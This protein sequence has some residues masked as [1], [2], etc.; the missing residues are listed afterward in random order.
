[1]GV[2]TDHKHDGARGSG[3]EVS[4]EDDMLLDVQEVAEILKVPVS[5]VYERTRRRGIER[6][7]HLKVGK[8]V[9]FRRSEI[10]GYLE[11]LRGG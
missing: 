6:L 3:A 11:T 8:Y 1:M 9:R 4:L 10:E 5:W 7:P 2:V